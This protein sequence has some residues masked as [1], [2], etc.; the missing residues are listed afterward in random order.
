ML[1]GLNRKF[2]IFLRQTWNLH[3]MSFK[4]QAQVLQLSS[5]KHQVGSSSFC[6]ITSIRAANWDFKVTNYKFQASKYSNNCF[7]AWIRVQQFKAK[8]SFCCLQF[9]QTRVASKHKNHPWKLSALCHYQS[10]AEIGM[11]SMKIAWKHLPSYLC[12]SIISCCSKAVLTSRVK[13]LEIIGKFSS[14]IRFH[15][16]S[17]RII[18]WNENNNIKSTSWCCAIAME[19]K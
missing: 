10:N 16:L 5:Y 14:I 12:V 11:N 18:S 6:Q 7:Q 2:D 19:K 4:S 15:V 13:R 3:V 9:F 17:Q 8:Q 1:L